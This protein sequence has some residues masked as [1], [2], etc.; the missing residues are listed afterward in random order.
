M[1]RGEFGEFEGTIDNDHRGSSFVLLKVDVNGDPD[2]ADSSTD[3][4][5]ARFAYAESPEDLMAGRIKGVRVWIY[6][7]EAVKFAAVILGAA[8]NGGQ[9]ERSHR[10]RSAKLEGRLTSRVLP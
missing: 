10:R 4:M 2:E 3:F 6:R 1:K 7:D 9:T 8:T 5:S